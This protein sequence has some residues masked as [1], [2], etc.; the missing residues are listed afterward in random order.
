MFTH[1]NISCRMRSALLATVATSAVAGFGA[2][3]AHA[4]TAIVVAE[5]NPGNPAVS[6]FALGAGSTPIRR[7]TGALTGLSSPE[8]IA[9]DRSGNLYVANSSGSITVYAPTAT[10]NVA[11]LRKIAGPATGLG[12]G[13]YGI[14][15][16]AA[17]DV[18]ASN[19]YLNSVTEYAPGANGNVAPIATLAGAA[20]GVK[21]PLGIALDPAGHLWVDS[22]GAIVEY[23]AGANG[24]VSPI[25]A[26]AGPQVN[27]TSV[28]DFDPAGNLFVT[29]NLPGPSGSFEYSVE[30]FAAGVSGDPAPIAT[31]HGA[32]TAL[33]G[34]SGLG[35]LPGTAEQLLV[36]NIFGAGSVTQYSVPASGD[37]KPAATPVAGGAV[38][39]PTGLLVV[40]PPTL[41]SPSQLHG[42][43]GTAFSQTLTGGG[44]HGRYSWA[45]ASGQLP[46][47]L[48]LDA[49]TGA[50]T[51][52]PTTPGTTS[53]TVRI[54]DQSLPAA[55]TATATVSITI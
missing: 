12:G 6:T 10:G 3:A 52:T 49:T 44:G 20:T 22:A 55:Q 29:A 37:L 36:S 26:I 23:P 14:A 5:N 35:I 13:V 16:D 33:S 21:Q 38:S 31:L 41:T 43:A 19:H 32:D 53:F 27:S 42:M 8:Q 40:A 24:N 30:E 39:Y 54:T 34:P 48:K 4:Q 7:I 17:G 46:T 2:A 9:A 50:I 11:P 47:G 51:G 25:A 45:I 28:I 18:Y 15:V 1:A